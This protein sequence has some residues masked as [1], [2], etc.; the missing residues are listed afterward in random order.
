M[1]APTKNAMTCTR[2]QVRCFDQASRL[3]QLAR[4]R[5]QRAFTV[6]I[7]SGKGGVGKS[8]LALNLSICLSDKGFA[9]TLV[10]VDMGLANAD[11]L[12][13]L[14]SRYNLSH[15]IT[16][17]RTVEEVLTT[18][19]AGIRVVPGVSG[20]LEAADLGDFQR[21]Q[22]IRQL[23][24]LESSADIMVLDC[25][26][27]ISRNVTGFALASDRVVVVTTDEPPALTDAYATIK[28]L[29][30]EACQAPIHLFVNMVKSRSDAAAAYERVTA[31]AKRFLNYP[32]AYA[33]YMLHDTHV[34]L[35][36]RQRCPFVIRYP[37]SNASACVAAMA[38]EV[39]STLPGK[40]RQSGLFSRVAGL[41]V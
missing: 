10:D 2:A 5:A 24:T 27:G 18:G 13:N 20:L 28:T 3:R 35:A 22:L 1:G 11:V 26:A 4:R 33:G 30:R 21:Q 6:A 29:H 25:G 32:V 19:P 39:A 15:V 9:V 34:E 31:V 8:N 41:F 40:R 7:T 12:M 23:Q 17:V 38:Q 37:G 16:G 36:V 14:H